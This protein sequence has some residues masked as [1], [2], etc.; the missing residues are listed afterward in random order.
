MYILIIKNDNFKSLLFANLDLKT[1][2][3]EVLFLI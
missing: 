1:N 2:Y 3:F